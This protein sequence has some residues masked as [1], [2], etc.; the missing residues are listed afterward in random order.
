MKLHY[1][2]DRQFF[3]YP[4]KYLI[5]SG[6]N[7]VAENFCDN[8]F[9]NAGFHVR[10]KQLVTESMIFLWSYNQP[11]KGS[12]AYILRMTFT[13]RLY[14]LMGHRFGAVASVDG[15]RMSADQIQALVISSFSD[16]CIRS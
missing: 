5:V 2:L 6:H 4:Q 3:K 9:T 10:A 13:G 15:S 12:I 14:R 16:T 11:P 7:S 1:L 8:V